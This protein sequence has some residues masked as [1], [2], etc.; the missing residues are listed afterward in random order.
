MLLDETLKE[1]LS[2]EQIQAIETAYTGKETELKALANKNAD[3]IFN[4]AAQKLA[5]Q[6]GIQKNENEK[7]S[8]YFIRLGLEWL[9]EQS[10]KKLEAAE[11]KVRLAEEKFTNH[12]GDETLKAELQKAKDELAKIPELLSKKDEEWKT[13]YDGLENTHKTFKFN[14]S[15]SDAMPKFD[16][17]VNQFELKAKQANAIDRIKKTYELSYDDNDNLIGTKDYQ[18]YLISDLLKSDEELKDLILIDQESGGGAGSGKKTITKG[19]NI[20]EGTGK[21]AAQEVVRV[22]MKTVENI[23]KLDPKYPDRFKELCKENNVL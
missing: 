16:D 21:G 2:P 9:P 23:D 5:E 8:D 19:L 22:Y 14:K 1:G 6:T 4:G 13:K 12:K 11:E 3:G 10:K 15:I 20:P 18:K 7:Y 17:N